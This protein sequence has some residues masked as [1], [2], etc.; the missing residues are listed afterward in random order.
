VNPEPTPARTTPCE[1]YNGMPAR[2]LGP[3]GWHKPWSAR[4][5][6]ACV[7]AKR[8]ADGRVAVRQSTDPDGPA[9]VY[10]PQ[11]MTAFIQGAKSGEADFLMAD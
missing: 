11:E 3:D 2:E 9:L 1:A 10:T 7:E 8:L 4:N 5:G 6:A